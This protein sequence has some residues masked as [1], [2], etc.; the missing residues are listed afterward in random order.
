MNRTRKFLA[1]GMASVAL[2]TTGC[3]GGQARKARRADTKAAGAQ[4]RQY[5]Q[6]QPVPRFTNSQL[7]QNLIEI[8]TAQVNATA[9][10]SFM[11][12][13]AGTGASG[14]LVKSCPSIGFPI[15]ATYQLTSPDQTAGDGAVVSQLEANGVFTG[16][17]TGTYVMCVGDDGKP[18]A[19]YHEGYVSTVTGPAHW[20][21]GKGEI[22]MDGSSSAKFTKVG[23]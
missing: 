14:P 21:T 6:A 13:L 7:R 8:E 3:T 10:T 2:L 20:D 23:G 11:F 1:I 5:Q 19:F 22:V 16:E 15:P 18:F 17:T 9:T 4:L 12:L